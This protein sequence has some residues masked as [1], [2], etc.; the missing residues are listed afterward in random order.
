MKIF[1]LLVVFL[2]L[3]PSISPTQQLERDIKLDVFFTDLVPELKKPEHRELLQS[4]QMDRDFFNRE[5]GEKV[6]AEIKNSNFLVKVPDRIM[7]CLTGRIESV[8]KGLLSDEITYIVYF[9]TAVRN[10]EPKPNKPLH[11]IPIKVN[12]PEGTPLNELLKPK[13]REAVDTIVREVIQKK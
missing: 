1:G 11:I 13:I 9:L 2:L 7:L 4:L 8:S 6:M 3:F 5:I 12:W 10:S